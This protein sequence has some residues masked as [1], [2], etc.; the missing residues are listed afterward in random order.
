M[1]ISS[2]QLREA[3]TRFFVE[4]GH[5]ALGAA[6]LVPVDPSV[7]FT[8]AGMVQFKPYFVGDE[9][10][11]VVRAT[12]IQPC[13]RMSDIDIIGTT[14]RHETL[15][16]MLGNFSFGD[17]FKEL[18]IPYAWELVTEVLGFEPGRLWV[19]I[20]ESDNDS[21]G[22]WQ[23]AAKLPAERIQ[24]M[25]EDNFWKMGDT[26]PCGPCSEIY[27]DRGESF[28][29]PGG[30][31]QG[32]SER[33]TEIWNLVF[34]QFERAADGTLTELPK[35]NIDT[36]AGLE[37][38]LTLLQGV[39]SLFETDL[40]APV[41]DSAAA[42][43]RSSVGRD[44]PT[45]VALRILADHARAATFLVSDGVFPSNEG[46][47]YVLRRVLRRAALRAHQLGVTEI[48]LPDLTDSVVATLGAA[49]PKL[50]RD[51]SLV[52]TVVGH[53]EE[54]FRRTLRA[55][56]QLIDSELEKGGSV[57]D[58]GAAFK[59]HD[60]Y[61]FP[62]DLTVEVAGARG[63]AVDRA[64]F[65]AAMAEQRARGREA[66]RKAAAESRHEGAREVLAE[67]GPTVFV[68]YT[69]TSGAARVLGVEA[70]LDAE[71]FENVDGDKAPPG[72]ELLDVFLDRTPFYAE[73]GGQVGDTG[74]LVGPTGSFRV[75]DAT[76]ADGIT[77]HTGYVTSGVLAAGA[78]VVATIDVERREAIRRNHTATH[79][80]HWALRAVL[81]E[82][83]R[84]Q[85]SLVAPDRLRFD[86]SH[87][88][89]VTPAELA[90]VED[91]VSMAIL[92][93]SPVRVDE[94]SR[95]EAERAGAIAFFGEKYGEIVRVVHAGPASVE[96]CGGTHVSALGTIGPFRIVS[97]SSIGAN[98]RRI[99]ATTGTGTLA[100]FRR[101]ESVVARATAAL[102]TSPDELGEAV[103]RL[104]VRER[105]L[106]DDL[107][108][109]EGQLRST[110]ARK[111]AATAE[112]GT[113][114][115]RRD[116]IDPAELRE[117]AL[118]VRR[119]DGVAAVGLIG[120]NG[121]DRVAIVVA[122]TKESGIDARAVA[123]AAAAVVGG[124][125]GGSPELATAGGRDV[126]AVDAALGTLHTLLGSS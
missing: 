51:A 113:V 85:G 43:T 75:L 35:K 110:E 36:G 58:G 97:E 10:P 1:T 15:F 107:R 73:S 78:E 69:E 119:E 22:I 27:F 95:V 14:A 56:S 102:H 82:H 81:G 115:A 9:T 64:G 79:L 6:S 19:T 80:L 99:E 20:H 121:D 104:V 74:T 18:A 96:L 38:I 84:Q 89:A 40:L 3:F 12:T 92:A 87:F 7:M 34:M 30:P 100:Q 111:L 125:G 4:R 65:E 2:D 17:Y 13:F 126:S 52:R 11:P 47:G 45:D 118:A 33:Y 63:V 49:Y 117:L 16:E 50:V 25:G 24:K 57:L 48:V 124:G 70:R 54:A 106:A 103:E 114:V 62:I 21:A 37:R 31:A 53:E 123:S 101:L 83:V 32:D 8:I 98:T 5:A 94:T 120:A 109:L 112:G 28:G 59:L 61:G 105:A 68:G 116:G 76:S 72:A 88:A 122:A 23:E 26:G 77:C 108:R 41:V 93:D 55:G 90:R 60:T 44:E 67:F 46:R 71:G 29:P 39:G 91:M 66:T 86:F 42:L